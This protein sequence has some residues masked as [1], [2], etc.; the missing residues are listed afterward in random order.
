MNFWRLNKKKLVIC[1]HY[2]ELTSRHI[3]HV[4]NF[5][6]KNIYDYF[7]Q[8]HFKYETNQHNT[9]STCGLLGHIL[10]N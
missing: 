7:N 6:E 4:V 5:G 1:V 2:S 9:V 3:V 10:V 8:F